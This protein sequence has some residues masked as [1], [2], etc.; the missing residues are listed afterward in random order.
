MNFSNVCLCFSSSGA[1]NNL[2]SFGK[3]GVNNISSLH[4]VPR[5][6]SLAVLFFLLRI[7]R[8][9]II[10]VMVLK[11]LGHSLDVRFNSDLIC[12]RYLSM[13]VF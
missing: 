8:L 9:L 1:S 12:L 10:E 3:P 7:G 11:Y 5:N 13:A 4:F 6:S 2:T